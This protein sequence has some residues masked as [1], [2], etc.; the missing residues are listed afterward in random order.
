MGLGNK[1]KMMIGAMLMVVGVVGVA[2]PVGA[3][4]RPAD[5]DCSNPSGSSNPAA[6]GVYCADP[7]NETELMDTVTNI[8]NLIIFVVG[9]VAVI[10]LVIGGVQYTMS[11]GDAT[12]VKKAKDT[13]LYAIIGL[14]VAILAFAIVNFVLDGLF[15]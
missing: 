13:I 1:W 2:L 3:A 9:V 14:V 8:I 15:S 12:Q 4:T 7:G 11:Q 5:C 10:M 6:C